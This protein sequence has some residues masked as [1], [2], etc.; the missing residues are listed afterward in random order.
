MSSPETQTISQMPSGSSP[1]RNRITLDLACHPGCPGDEKQDRAQSQHAQK[2]RA[3][4]DVIDGGDAPDQ[5]GQT[6]DPAAAV[7]E[8][9]AL[10]MLGGPQDDLAG[11][12]SRTDCHA[13]SGSDHESGVHQE[14]ADGSHG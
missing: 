7:D 9:I 11:Q 8:R 10:E 1:V 14:K 2:S 3:G 13:S 12:N 5:A 4:A 6:A